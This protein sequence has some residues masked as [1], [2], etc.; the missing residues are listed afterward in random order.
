MH[1]WRSSQREDGF[2]RYG[3]GH[4]QNAVPHHKAYWRGKRNPSKPRHLPEESTKV[5]WRLDSLPHNLSIQWF[6]WGSIHWSTTE[7]YDPCQASHQDSPRQR[8]DKYPWVLPLP[9]HYS[10]TSH[11]HNGNR[12]LSAYTQ[13]QSQYLPWDN[14]RKPC[15][16]PI[17]RMIWRFVL[18]FGSDGSHHS[19]YQIS[20]GYTEVRSL[21]FPDQTDLAWR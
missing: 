12:L 1:T 7:E 17:G 4:Y 20:V 19:W 2:P 5:P 14:V 16:L 18:S 13:T 15:Y 8:I 3:P 21:L 6:A 10:S 9:R 11:L